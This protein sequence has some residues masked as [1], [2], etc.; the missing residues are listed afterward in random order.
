MLEGIQNFLCVDLRLKATPR[1]IVPIP[2]WDVGSIPDAERRTLDALFEDDIR[3]SA[4]LSELRLT[5]WLEP[6]YQELMEPA[7]IS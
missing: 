2:S 4:E 7:Q 3:K 1:Y 5:D 6:Q